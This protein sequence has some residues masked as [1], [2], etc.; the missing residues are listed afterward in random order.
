MHVNDPFIF[1]IT[2]VNHRKPDAGSARSLQPT[3]AVSCSSVC[4]ITC[5]MAKSFTPLCPW[6]LSVHIQTYAYG[7]AVPAR[8]QHEAVVYGIGYE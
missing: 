2:D 7:A 3:A 8:L 6:Q 1:L 5:A 4:M